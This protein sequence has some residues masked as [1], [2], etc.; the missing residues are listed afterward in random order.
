MFPSPTKVSRIPKP[1]FVP[2][3][4]LS[5]PDIPLGKW[6]CPISREIKQSISLML[7]T[8][9]D[10]EGPLYHSEGYSA[11]FGGARKLNH[12]HSTLIRTVQSGVLMMRI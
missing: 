11:R 3:Q 6:D 9:L 8:S 4:S 7:T 10:V 12:F 2:N 5:L 1:F